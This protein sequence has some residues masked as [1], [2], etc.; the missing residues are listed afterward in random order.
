MAKSIVASRDRKKNSILK[1]SDLAFKSPGDG[2]RAYEYE[3]FLNKKIKVE[4]KKDQ[5]FKKIFV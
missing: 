3:Y 4:L 2:L 1:L 5:K